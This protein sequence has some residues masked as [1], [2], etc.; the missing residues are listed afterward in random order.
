M[1]TGQPL[2]DYHEKLGV[3]LIKRV[4]VQKCK[5]SIEKLEKS[6]VRE[7]IVGSSMPRYQ[8]DDLGG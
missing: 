1:N 3:K 4:P 7:L 5:V 8:S 6:A 2:I